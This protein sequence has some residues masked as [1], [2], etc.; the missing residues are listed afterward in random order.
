MNIKFSEKAMPR[1]LKC[2]E[3]ERDH[4]DNS[5]SQCLQ[6]LMRWVSR[7]DEQGNPIW[8]DGDYIYIVPDSCNDYSFDWSIRYKDGRV[9]VCG[10]MLYHGYKGEKDTSCSVTFDTNAWQI[11]T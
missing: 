8:D 2:F 4:H 7:R 6:K 5:F 1:A 10:G 11:H 3:I 9:G